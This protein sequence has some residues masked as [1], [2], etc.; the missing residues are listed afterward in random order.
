M[1]DDG[2]IRR[3]LLFMPGDDLKKITRAASSGA[4][5]IIMDIEDG[6]ALGSKQT[7]RETIHH[8]L[9]SGE[10]DFGHS[11]KLVRLNSVSSGLLAD[12]I[13][14]TFDAHP[15]G[16]L[17]PKAETADEMS[18]V[19]ENLS[20]RERKAGL[21][22]HAIK[23]IPIIE[24]ARG[25]VNLKEIALTDDRVVAL[26][27][28][29]EDLAGSLGA[30]RTPD[31]MEV[32]YGRS[33]VV[34]HAAA[35]GLQ[36]LDSPC[37]RPGDV[38]TLTNETRTALQ[39]GYTGKLAIHP[40]QIERIVSVFTPSDSEIDTARRLI[41]AHSQHQD[42]GTGVFTFEGKMVDWPMIRTAQRVVSRARASGKM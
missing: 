8:A 32:F 11:E 14:A 17:L 10:V 40:N 24:T 6:V 25:I 20:N 2:R 36:A 37:V 23:L 33:A 42:A 35:F 1:A 21:P 34:M 22:Y 16:Y 5:S 26:A 19:C 28:G 9:T 39:M 29:A 41:E 38:E 27:F 12:D 4:D 7:A 30:V 3:A 18:A 15:D 31:G 13:A